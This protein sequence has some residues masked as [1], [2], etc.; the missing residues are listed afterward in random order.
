MSHPQKPLLTLPLPKTGPFNHLAHSTP[1]HSPYVALVFFPAVSPPGLLACVLS[2]VQ[3]D[4][5]HKAKN[6]DLFIAVCPTPESTA[7][8]IVGVQ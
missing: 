3:E 7:W 1:P 5:F 8:N 4:K 2:P 6:L